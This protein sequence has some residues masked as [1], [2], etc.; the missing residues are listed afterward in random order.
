MLY[1]S[2]NNAF[3]LNNQQAPCT[4][5]TLAITWPGIPHEFGP[6]HSGSVGYY[7]VTFEL[8]DGRRALS[9]PLNEVLSEYVGTPVPPLAMTSRPTDRLARQIASLIERIASH[10]CQSMPIELLKAYHAAGELLGVIAQEALHAPEKTVDVMQEARWHLLQR[11]AEPIGIV[12]LAR[13]LGI[14]QEYLSRAFRARFG[15]SPL[16]FR[17]D[18]RIDAAVRLLGSGA[19]S[20]KEVAS[21]LGFADVQTFTKAFVRHRGQTPGKLARELAHA[22]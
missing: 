16:Q 13:E 20:C 3:L 14:S 12:E 8:H 10:A 19:L 9:L 6:V 11:F 22:R 4:P 17:Q 2:G 1:T 15:V 21:R 5:G 7:E 18:L